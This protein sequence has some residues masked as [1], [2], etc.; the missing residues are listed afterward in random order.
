M[1]SFRNRKL[2]HRPLIDGFLWEF[3]RIFPILSR[4]PRNRNR[5]A[6]HV[7]H[8]AKQAARP[9]TGRAAR[10]IDSVLF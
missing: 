1:M 9:K 10:C 8:T 3:Y 5:E 2:I 6:R 7:R 4:F